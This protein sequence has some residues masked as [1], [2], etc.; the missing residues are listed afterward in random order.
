MM[1][2]LLQVV[3]AML[4]VIGP[5]MAEAQ[6]VDNIIGVKRVKVQQMLRPYRILDYQRDKVTY[7]IEKGIRQTVLYVNDTCASFLWA[8]NTEQMPA[9]MSSLEKAGYLQLREGS[10]S[11]EGLM[12]EMRPLDSGKAMVFSARRGMSAATE[13]GGAVAVADAGAAGRSEA[14]TGPKHPVSSGKKVGKKKRPDRYANVPMNH[15]KA[16]VIDMPLMQQEVQREKAKPVKEVKDPARNWVGE[17][18]GSAR[19]LGWD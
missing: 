4:L 9:F 15:G 2:R 6:P 3:L 8:V 11:K 19:L 17:A 10:L 5:A 14:E 12:V 1:I 16:V 7:Q 13:Q 18:E